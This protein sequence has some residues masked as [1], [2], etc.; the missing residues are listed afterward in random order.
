M[1]GF[2][3]DSFATYFEAVTTEKQDAHSKRQTTCIDI[4]CLR[5]LSLLVCRGKKEE[6]AAYL[7][8]L[9]N[10]EYQFGGETS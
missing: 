1:N 6:K 7:A 3:K 10:K 9:C 5:V 4:F 8:A 2:G